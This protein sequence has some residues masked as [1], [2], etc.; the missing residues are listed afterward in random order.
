MVT[1]TQ[2]KGH[3]ARRA[4]SQLYA[5]PSPRWV[6]VEFNDA[7]VADTR[8][9]LLVW[10]TRGIPLY[11]FPREDVRLD[12]LQESDKVAR[13]PSQGETVHWHVKVVDRIAEDAASAHP[14]PP[15]ELAELSDY[16]TFK[17]SAMDAWYEEEERIY[18]HP[19]DPYKRVDVLPSSRHVK[20]ELDGV[21]LADSHRPHLLFETGLPT[22]YYLP[23]QDVR[24]DLLEATDKHTRCPYKGKASYYSLHL[25]GDVHAN[26]VWTYPDPIP[27]CPKIEGLLSFYNEKV[28]LIVD[29]ERLP[30]PE[31]PWS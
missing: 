1:K 26:L 30:R 25:D 24:M 19:R 22:R 21:T 12:L 5:E 29:G 7:Y 11:Y 3:P 27:E 20:V 10:D 18:V 23:R 2:D 16:L 13:Y 28:D 9:A 31:S 6:R 8:R 14:D 4:E 15:E 17:W